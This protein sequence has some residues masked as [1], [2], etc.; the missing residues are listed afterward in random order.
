MLKD[1]SK[2]AALFEQGVYV[3]QLSLKILPCPDHCLLPFNGPHQVGHNRVQVE[4]NEDGM[5][6]INRNYPLVMHGT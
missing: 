2:V 3:V 6:R 5:K 4:I 1:G